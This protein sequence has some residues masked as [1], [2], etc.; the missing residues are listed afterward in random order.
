MQSSWTGRTGN[1]KPY[2]AGGHILQEISDMLWRSKG[3]IS[4]E[5]RRNSAPPCDVYTPCRVHARATARKRKSGKLPR[6]K[7]ESIGS[8]VRQKLADEWPPE[9]IAGR[10][11]QDMSGAASATRP[12]TSTSITRR[13]KGGRN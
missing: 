4:G 3:S 8:H 2:E 5:L 12:Y 7:N 13:P 10:A 1:N 9:I 6:L 11:G